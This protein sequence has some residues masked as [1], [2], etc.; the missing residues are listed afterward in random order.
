MLTNKL[1]FFFNE[2]C[3]DGWSER[4]VNVLQT[5][6]HAVINGSYQNIWIK[7]NWVTC[8]NLKIS[9]IISTILFKKLRKAQLATAGVVVVS[10]RS[11]FAD[12]QFANG[13]GGFANVSSK[14]ITY[15]GSFR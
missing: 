2:A 8:C 11:R 9:L 10:P 5:I 3:E 1:I 6:I 7:Q 4:K 15:H 13:S 14:L 12:D